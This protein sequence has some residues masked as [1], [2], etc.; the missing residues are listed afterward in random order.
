MSTDL[1]YAIFRIRQRQ[2]HDLGEQRDLEQLFLAFVDGRIGA[3]EYER[4]VQRF[5]LISSASPSSGR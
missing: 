5:F 4:R 1:A 2:A 3:D